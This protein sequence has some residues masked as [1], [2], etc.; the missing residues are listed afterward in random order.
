MAYELRDYQIESIEKGIK[1]L[2][3]KSQKNSIIVAPT[4][5]GKS[6]II[7]NIAKV[8]AGN[9][10]IF[11][12]SKE[13]LEQNYE[14]YTSYGE[15]ADIYSASAGQKTIGKVTFATIGSVVNKPELFN[16]FQYCIV[17][18][19]FPRGSLV[20]G[21]AIEEIKVGDLINSYNHKKNI[22][23]KKKVVATSRKTHYGNLIELKT[24]RGDA[25]FCTPN[26]PIF[27]KKLG[28]IPAYLLYL[29]INE[30][31]NIGSDHLEK[32]K[33]ILHDLRRDSFRRIS[34][35]EKK[36]LL[37]SKMLSH[38]L[39]TK[40]TKNR[41]EVFLLWRT[42]DTNGVQKKIFFK[43]K[44]SILFKR[45]FGASAISK[46][47]RTREESQRIVGMEGKSLKE[48]ERKK[49]NVD[50]WHKR[51]NDR[52][53][54]GQ[55]IFRQR[56][57]RQINKATNFI[58]LRN[59]TANGIPYLDKR[60]KTHVPIAAELLQSRF[61]VSSKKDCYRSRRG[62]SQT[63]K[64][65][66]LRPS[67][68]GGFE[69]VGVESCSI[70]ERGSR[71]KSGSL[72]KENYVYNLEVEGNHNYFVSNI[73]VHNCDLV[74]PTDGT[75][76]KKFFSALKLKVLGLTAT[77]IRM[78]R[79][80]FPFPHSK[81]CM[82]DRMR[83]KFFQEYLHI[84]QIQELVKRGYFANVEYYQYDFDG[85]RLVINSTGGDYTEN[86]IEIALTANSTLE[87][88]VSL[89]DSLQSKH[90]LIFVESVRSAHKLQEMLGVES[91]GLVKATMNKKEREFILNDFKQGKIKAV[92][93]VGIL[94][95][96]FDFPELDCI[97]MARPTMSLR[98]YYQIIGRC[99]R[100]HPTKSRSDVFDFVGNFGKFGKVSD[101]VI[102]KKNGLWV[103]HNG[104]NILTNV[105]LSEIESEETA[106][107]KE[108]E[109]HFGKYKGTKLSE[110]PKD[111]MIWL[112]ENVGKNKYNKY[113]FDYIKHEINV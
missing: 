93:N 7:A 48:N 77:P 68:N 52:I 18:E 81:L 35:E 75:M 60:S 64:M 23:E 54:K 43:I 99:V 65:E 46:T 96:G 24:E 111:Y 39:A 108:P 27:V 101:L 10:I 55:N 74:S 11:Q 67:E 22:L 110:I 2:L 49:S 61:S 1:F 5:S 94:T 16:E 72:C 109:I 57:Q 53:I 104:K 83:P 51:K 103:I 91:C 38:K 71:Y 3:G 28:Y 30:L 9:T 56:W 76:Y 100:P 88:I 69:F 12:P 73:L 33:E 87:K 92:V 107:D 97:I 6:L 36:S 58:T 19:C 31:S 26:H 34:S 25:F 90:V 82:L 13:L 95:V 45:M 70:H 4:G 37:R 47:N 8:L 50:G 59:R 32:S 80:N 78:K 44:Q 106:I 105:S 112:K 41:N 85:S 14:K 17:D 29:R 42:L 15:V 20:D 86:S 40:N 98:L 84:I 79:Y 89:F 102:E 21:K 113:I 63:K 62:F 66:I